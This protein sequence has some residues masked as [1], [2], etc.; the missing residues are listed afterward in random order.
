MFNTTYNR[1]AA[2]FARHRAPEA[3]LQ[4]H[5]DE[6]AAEYRRQV[7]NEEDAHRFFQHHQELADRASVELGRLLGEFRNFM[8]LNAELFAARAVSRE[9]EDYLGLQPTTDSFPFQSANPS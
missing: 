4:Q 6:I 9:L 2:F 5:H 7:T 1:I 8:F 3:D